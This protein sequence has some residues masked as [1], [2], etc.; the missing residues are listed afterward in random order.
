MRRRMSADAAKLAHV[1]RREAPPLL[2]LLPLLLLPPLRLL[3]PLPLA[4]AGNDDRSRPWR[5][6]PPSCNGLKVLPSTAAAAA[7]A[8][9]MPTRHALVRLRC[10]QS[11][12]CPAILAL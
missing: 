1:S 11:A 2:L 8:Q 9:C 4:M 7:A 3:L 6:H 5:G 12:R 10:D